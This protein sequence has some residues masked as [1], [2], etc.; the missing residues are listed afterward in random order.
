MLVISGTFQLRW[1]KGADSCPLRSS[2]TIDGI[3]SLLFL[4]TRFLSKGSRVAG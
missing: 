4:I 1:M 2:G 3:P